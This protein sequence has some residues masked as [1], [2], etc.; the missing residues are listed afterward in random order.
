MPVERAFYAINKDRKDRGRFLVSQIRQETVV[1][2]I[3][4]SV[5]GMDA[6][7]INTVADIIFSNLMG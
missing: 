2:A 7:I 1:N 4:A 6:S 5:V 3:G